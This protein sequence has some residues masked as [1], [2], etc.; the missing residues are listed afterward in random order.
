MKLRGVTPE[1][2]NRLAKIAQMEE[3]EYGLMGGSPLDEED[4]ASYDADDLVMFIENTGELYPQ[5]QSIQKNLIQKIKRG[6]FDPLLAPRLWGYLVESGA[7]QYV[8]DMGMDQPWHKAFPPAV[9]QEAAQQ[10]A[11]YF[12][13]EVEDALHFDESVDLKDHFGV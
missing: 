11:N 3:E 12:D 7:K 13:Q 2:M 4:N 6:V 10:L 5:K 1:G 8:Q 9:R